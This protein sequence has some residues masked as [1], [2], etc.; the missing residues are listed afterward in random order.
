MNFQAFLIGFCFED[1]V[2]GVGN[3]V[4]NFIRRMFC[5]LGPQGGREGREGPEMILIGEEDDEDGEGEEDKEDKEDEEAE[6]PILIALRVISASIAGVRRVPR[7]ALNAAKS[8]G[9]EMSA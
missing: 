9:E 5:R 6:E 1:P 2:P 4:V 8:S 3:V 7:F